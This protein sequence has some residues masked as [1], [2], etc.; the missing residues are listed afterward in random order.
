MT[1]WLCKVPLKLCQK[2]RGVL[3][4]KI[5]LHKIDMCDAVAVDELFA[6]QKF[7]GVIESSAA[8]TGGRVTPLFTESCMHGEHDGTER[9]ALRLSGQPDNQACSHTQSGRKSSL[10]IKFLGGI[11]LRRDIPDP[12]PVLLF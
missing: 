7:D 10:K 1:L 11:L 8:A 5:P 6:A 12:S 3:Y 4:R 9:H 2:K